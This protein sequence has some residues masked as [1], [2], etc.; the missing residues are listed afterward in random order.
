MNFTRREILENRSLYNEIKDLV[1]IATEFKYHH[2]PCYRCFTRNIDNVKESVQ[3]Y[4]KGDFVKVEK[5]IMENIIAAHQVVSLKALHKTCNSGD[6]DRRYCFKLNER[7]VKQFANDILFVSL[8]LPNSSCKLKKRIRKQFANDIL[9]VY[10]LFQTAVEISREVLEENH[11]TQC[12][13][14]DTAVRYA[15]E[16]MTNDII[17]H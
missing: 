6:A 8:P 7:I 16:T 14:E 17:T 1:L 10:Y 9:F 13:T 11:L 3:Q 2:V 15:A 4:E 5:F 12:F